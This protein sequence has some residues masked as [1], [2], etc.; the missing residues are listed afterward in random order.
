MKIFFWPD[1][2]VPF[3]HPVSVALVRQ[4]VADWSPDVF[5]CLGDFADMFSVSSHSRDPRRKLLLEDELHAVR[6]ELRAVER[7]MPAGCRRIFLEGNHEWRLSRYLHDRAPELASLRGMSFRALCD[8]DANKWEWV[9]YMRHK[10]IGRLYL[11]HECG[12]AGKYAVHATGAAYGGN[13]AIGHT[14]RLGLHYFGDARGRSFV[15]ATFG[16]L[17]DAAN[18]GYGHEASKARD[19]QLG[20]GIGRLLKSGDVHLQAVPIVNGKCV[21]EGKLYT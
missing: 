16:W 19:W 18:I 14:H 1:T 8:L 5:V 3:H 7:A 17:G 2:H 13:I 6:D 9:P 11:T 4:V 12:F 21:V 10:K 15:S 20:F